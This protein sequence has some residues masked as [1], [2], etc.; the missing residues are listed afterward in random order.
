MK[1]LFR[2]I[3]ATALGMC[4]LVPFAG[5][6][7]CA[8]QDEGTAKSYVAL[9]IN[10]SVELILDKNDDVLSVTAANED[11]RVLL[12]GESGIVGEHVSVAVD[13]IASL[14]EEYGY[15]SASNAVIGVNV[16]SVLGEDHEAQLQSEIDTQ[17][18]VTSESF[19]F[20]VTMSTEGAWSVLRALTDLKAKYPDN[21][22]IQALTV[23]RFRIILSAQEGDPTLT[24]EAAV[25]MDEE[26][27]L[28]MA[29]DAA[30]RVEAYATEAYNAAVA[31][32]ERAYEKAKASFLQTSL[33]ALYTLHSPAEGAVYNM[34][35]TAAYGL[36]FIAD[37]AEYAAQIGNAPFTEEQ[38]A[39]VCAAFG[40]D[41]TEKAALEDAD[42]QVNLNGVL[43]YADRLFKNSPAGQSLEEMK[44]R[45]D[46]LLKEVESEVAA[47]I[48]RL[49]AEYSEEIEAV[50]DAAERFADTAG[51]LVPEW[52][53]NYFDEF[54][55]ML[56]TLRTSLSDGMTVENLREAATAFNKKKA[57]VEETIR[58]KLSEETVAEIDAVQ[59]NI[60]ERLD[61]AK[62]ALQKAVET[63]K[64]E[65]EAYLAACKADRREGTA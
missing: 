27:L 15:L 22:G 43:A 41:E 17:C 28:Q 23:S 44:S 39:R 12:Y 4:M 54:A 40:L 21:E 14:A 5:F 45:L 65:A 18:A 50:L 38:I 59:A 61:A 1:K 56:T 35:A 60:E 48:S 51:V 30:E 36:N 29:A 34:Y 20:S 47:E 16:S 19:D 31:A 37:A 10:P 26:E 33:S 42:G 58:A 64:E 55:S 32:A 3:M 57:E 11:A 2:G 7:A 63:A 46:V 49:S 25:E 53:E 9:D 62:A 6:M 13:R 8:P 24:V 52:L